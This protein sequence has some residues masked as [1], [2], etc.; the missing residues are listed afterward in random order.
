[1]AK[2]KEM[3]QDELEQLIEQKVIEILG[4]PDEGLSLNEAFKEKLKKRLAKASPK[5]A[6]REVVRRFEN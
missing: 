5:V 4:D 1:M 3:T 2:V 6:H